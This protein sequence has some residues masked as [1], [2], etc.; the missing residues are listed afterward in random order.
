[1]LVMSARSKARATRPFLNIRVARDSAGTQTGQTRIV[2]FVIAWFRQLSI[3]SLASA[4]QRVVH[5]RL[6]PPIDPISVRGE[7]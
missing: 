3:L 4:N 5:V 6:L 7:S 2:S 1:M